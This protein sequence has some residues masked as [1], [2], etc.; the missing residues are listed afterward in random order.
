MNKTDEP[1]RGPQ[2]RL[3]ITYQTSN[4]GAECLN[5]KRDSLLVAAHERVV[6]P[7][8]LLSWSRRQQQSPKLSLP[9]IIPSLDALL[10]DT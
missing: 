3:L 2:A 1:E 10:A 5:K 4:F 6:S 7:V 9:D 8:L